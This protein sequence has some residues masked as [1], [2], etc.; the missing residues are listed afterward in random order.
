MIQLNKILNDVEGYVRDLLKT[1]LPKTLVFHNIKHTLEV[2]NAAAEIGSHC[3]F[4]SEQINIVQVAA[5][6]HDCGYT[7]TYIGHEAISQELAKDFLLRDSYP[8][9]FVTRV[10]ECI[11]ATKY[12]QLPFS[13]ESMVLCDADLYHFTRPNYHW[14]EEALRKE[15]QEYFDKH[16]TDAGWAQTNCDMLTFQVLRIYFSI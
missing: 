6:F 9:D 5:W 2:V 11:E 4:T 14:Y 12:P 8:P 10:L 15:F 16:Q 13:I 7:Q 3:N 1:E